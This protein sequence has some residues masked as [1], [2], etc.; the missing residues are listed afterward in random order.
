MN[1]DP[2]SAPKGSGIAFAAWLMSGPGYAVGKEKK[3]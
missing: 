1:G 2:R 3:G